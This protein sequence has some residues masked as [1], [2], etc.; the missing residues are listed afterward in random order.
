MLTCMVMLDSVQSVLS[1]S[2]PFTRLILVITPRILQKIPNDA[3]MGEK[4]V[5]FSPIKLVWK[6]AFHRRFAKAR[7]AN[8][9]GKSTEI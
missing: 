7:Y 1:M 9:Y 2:R 4:C 8:E 5:H 6:S 3:V